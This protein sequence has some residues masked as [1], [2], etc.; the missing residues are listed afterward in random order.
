MPPQSGVSEGT[1]GDGVDKQSTP[2]EPTV[3]D[4]QNVTGNASISNQPLN[5][6]V[7]DAA[8]PS[9]DDSQ[10]P[11]DDAA[12]VS[13]SDDTQAQVDPIVK[14]M[15]K[16]VAPPSIPVEQTKKM[17]DEDD[18]PSEQT[19][20]SVPSDS[21]DTSSLPQ[22]TPA[23][24]PTMSS[25]MAADPVQK[26]EEKKPEGE[27]LPAGQPGTPTGGGSF[28]IPP[29][30]QTVGPTDQSQT[31]PIPPS[32]GGDAAP[33]QPL[34]Q[35]INDTAEEQTLQK[36]HEPVLIL[37]EDYHAAMAIP[38]KVRVSSIPHP[39]N[40]DHYIQSIELFANGTSVGKVDLNP[41]E[42]EVAEAEFQVNVQEG[43]V[44]RAVARCNKHGDWS[45]EKTA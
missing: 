6:Q 30:S 43:M 37:P 4:T 34:P 40:E 44:L 1:A 27:V 18:K 38:I 3:V 15:A 10:Q 24:Q 31:Q 36:A 39:M 41:K 11:S 13:S 7:S 25:P 33:T 2:S 17:P 32:P 14:D 42:N 29:A 35:A 45:V 20:G 21:Q 12:T 26:I 22:G 8:T 23:T 19:Q 28:Q 5:P 16:P 9:S